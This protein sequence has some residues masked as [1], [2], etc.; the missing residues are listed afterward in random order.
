[1][2]VWDNVRQIAVF[3]DT[4]SLAYYIHDS[5][6]AAELCRALDGVQ[7]QVKAVRL[8]IMIFMPLRPSG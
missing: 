8:A 4:F 6:S 2:F 3:S 7:L 5:D 1:M